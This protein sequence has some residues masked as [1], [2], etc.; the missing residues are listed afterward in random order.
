MTKK[1][2]SSLMNKCDATIE[3]KTKSSQKTIC[4]HSSVFNDVNVTSLMTTSLLVLESTSHGSQRGKAET[5]GSRLG[6][7]VIHEFE[8]KAKIQ[9]NTW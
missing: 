9:S 4:D 3:T 8:R 5:N 7:R 6:K 1:P 2:I